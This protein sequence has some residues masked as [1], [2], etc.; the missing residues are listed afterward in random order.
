MAFINRCLSHD[1]HVTLNSENE[2]YGL[3]TLATALI[4][5]CN[6]PISYFDHLYKLNLKSVKYCWLE[7]DLIFTYA[8][9]FAFA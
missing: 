4:N 2:N 6:I 3:V 8:T 1:S 5:T 9:K 7:F